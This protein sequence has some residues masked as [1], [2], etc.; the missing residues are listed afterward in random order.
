MATM[1][2]RQGQGRLHEGPF[3]ASVRRFHA[4]RN[5]RRMRTA[6]DKVASQFGPNM[7]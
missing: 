2:P 7:T 6:L 1:K 4:R 5:V 3:R